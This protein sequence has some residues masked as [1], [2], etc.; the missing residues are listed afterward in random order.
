MGKAWASL[1]CLLLFMTLLTGCWDRRELEERTSVIA[2]GIDLVEGRQNLYKLT[3]Q[4]PIPIKIAGSS[5]QGGGGN[6]DAVKIMSVTGKTVTDAVNNLQQRL[7]Q[8]IFLGHTRVLAISEDVARR[9]MDDIIDSFRRDPQIRR[10][11]WP[12]VVQG[13]A[14]DLLEM[15]PGLIQIPVVFLMDL[16]ENGTKM[17]T[18]PDQTM[19]EYLIQTSNETL[20]PMLNYVQAYKDDVKWKG[21]AVFRDQKMVGSLNDIHTWALLQLRDEKRGGD[22]IVPLPGKGGGYISFRP[23]F[24]R[25]KLEMKGSHATG[26][27]NHSGHGVAYLCEIQG[28]I[29]EMTKNVE[30]SPEEVIVMLQKLIKKEMEKRARKM[31]DILQKQYNSDILKLGLA[32]RGHHYA[33]YWRKHDWFKDFKQFP[34]E[35]KYTIKLRRLGMEMH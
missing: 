22:V 4:I 23:H 31:L 34:I 24:V 7:N 11:M 2:L 20:Q 26:Q 10:L 12:V 13:R 16:I 17:G 6:K 25:T 5:G 27:D 35:V 21:V 30:G 9:G 32:M 8:R 18:I 19:G 28:D 15:K 1:C 29:I 3:V 14:A 33:D